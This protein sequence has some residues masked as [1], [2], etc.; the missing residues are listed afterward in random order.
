MSSYK[1]TVKYD[2]PIGFYTF[3]GE[4][5]DA[6]GF[7]DGQPRTIFDEMGNQPATLMVDNAI[8][9]GHRMGTSSLLELEHS[10]EYSFT[11]GG[12]QWLEEQ[13][14]DWWP[15]NWIEI[16]YNGLYDFPSGSF[17][18]E[19]LFEKDVS[20]YNYGG[21]FRP[22]VDRPLIF[23][24]DIFRIWF[25]SYIY[26]DELFMHFDYPDG[27]TMYFDWDSIRGWVGDNRTWYLIFQWRLE[28]TGPNTWTGHAEVY[29]NG[30]RILHQTHSYVDDFP[31]LASTN[32]IYIGGDPFIDATTNPTDYWAKDRFTEEAKFDNIAFYDRAL[33]EQEIAWHMTKIWGFP[34]FIYRTWGTKYW[35][36]NDLSDD[37][38]EG[39]ATAYLG[40]PR[41]LLAGTQGVQYIKEQEG[42]IPGAGSLGMTFLNGGMV[43]LSSSG[44]PQPWYS[45]FYYAFWFKTG[46]NNQGTLMSVQQYEYPFTGLLVQMNSRNNGA[47][48]GSVQVTTS[49]DS[50]V[51]NSIELDGFGQ[52]IRYNDGEWH[53][54]AIRRK[55][56]DVS[57]WLDGVLQ[58]EQFHSI[59]TVGDP[60]QWFMLNMMPGFNGISAT[61]S[62]IM[63]YS[64][65][66]PDHYIWAH[67]NYRSTFRIRG[68]VTLQGV[69][70]I[71]RVRFYDHYTGELIKQTDTEA[72]T[73]FYEEYFLN[74]ALIDIYVFDPN[75]STVRY[76]AYGPVKPSEVEDLEVPI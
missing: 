8:Y 68:V 24:P 57:F 42:P 20:P 36:M 46:D 58:D 76:R 4:S 31:I 50:Y 51:F 69:P 27:N 54:L 11:F 5:F 37:I 63:F 64:W 17:A 15:K 72:I 47:H 14:D 2:E 65:G 48:I 66:I 49:V 29:V 56:G 35:R 74:N 21:S 75:D 12:R 71:A 73:G 41:G 59:G 67:V 22:R 7:Y 13:H 33:T 39:E 1:D 26:D 18:V 60:S 52:P 3:D 43:Q 53:H 16:P 25:D 30:Y 38:V 19:F 9:W 61:L 32:N 28:V 70:H 10:E 55:S 23:K 62:E 45:E 6:S 44:S 34:N 40:G